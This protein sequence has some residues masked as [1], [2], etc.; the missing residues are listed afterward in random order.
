MK[1]FR[2]D[3]SGSVGLGMIDQQG[4]K[5]TSQGITT[6]STEIFLNS[7]A[8]RTFLSGSSFMRMSVKRS[9]M[10]FNTFLALQIH[11]KLFAWDS[12]MLNMR[13][14]AIWKFPKNLFSFSKAQLPYADPMIR[15]SFQRIHSKRIG[16]L[17]WP[18]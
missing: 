12:T 7:E 6:I 9:K 11:P 17:N 15:S 8:H 5:L 10:T 18:S 2:Y 3:R 14:R 4:K 1:I 13:E 16:K